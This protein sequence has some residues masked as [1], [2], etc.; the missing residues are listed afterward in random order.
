[1]TICSNSLGD[2]IG[3]LFHR[4]CSR[5]KPE[6]LGNQ[7][8]NMV[9]CKRSLNSRANKNVT[10]VI[11]LAFSLFWDFWADKQTKIHPWAKKLMLPVKVETFLWWLRHTGHEMSLKLSK[12]KESSKRKALKIW[13]LLKSEEIGVNYKGIFIK[14]NKTKVFR[15]KHSISQ[16]KRSKAENKGKKEKEIA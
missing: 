4:N 5:F 9:N 10:N 13:N 3:F 2:T 1:M 14:F 8:L 15:I 12:D 6:L 7:L 11:W 16:S